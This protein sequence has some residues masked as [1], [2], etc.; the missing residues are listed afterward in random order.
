MYI[1]ISAVSDDYGYLKVLFQDIRDHASE[2]ADYFNQRDK[3]DFLHCFQSILNVIDPLQIS[4]GVVTECC[5]KF[6]VN[7]NCKGMV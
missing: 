6:D 2:N 4:L 1:W 5:H 3:T 7:E